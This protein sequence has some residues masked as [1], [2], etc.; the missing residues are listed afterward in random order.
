MELCPYALLGLRLQSSIMTPDRYGD[1]WYMFATTIAIIHTIL[2]NLSGKLGYFRE[3]VGF[4]QPCE[5]AV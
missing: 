5:I 3:G 1:F 4:R 2:N